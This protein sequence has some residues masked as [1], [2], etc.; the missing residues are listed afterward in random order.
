MVGRERVKGGWVPLAPTDGSRGLWVQVLLGFNSIF[1]G[2]EEQVDSARPRADQAGSAASLCHL[3][4]AF[5][6]VVCAAALT[7]ATQR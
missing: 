1:E 2:E 3:A 5:V 4:N 7:G 6:P